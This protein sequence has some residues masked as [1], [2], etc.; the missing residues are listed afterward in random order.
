MKKG[1]MDELC[2]KVLDR[3]RVLCSRREY[4]S[5][6]MLEKAAEYLSR[7][8]CPPAEVPGMAASIV[9]ALRKDRYVDDLRYASAFA[10]DK[11]VLSGWGGIK[12]RHALSAKG[13]GM[14]VISGALQE[15]DREQ[16]DTRLL[17]LLQTK[18]KALEGDPQS[19]L[20][21]LRFA[22]GRGYCYDEVSR[23]VRQLDAADSG[24]E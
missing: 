6:D 3:L 19:R 13:I 15:I 9:E 20:K 5:G 18:K 17:K 4:C 21:L 14:E 16:A 2:I 24:H 8:G 22:L 1:V 11:A 10:R 7:Y 23:M 12:I